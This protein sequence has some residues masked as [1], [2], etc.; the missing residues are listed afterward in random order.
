ML[1]IKELRKQLEMTQVDLAIEMGVSQNT[2]SNW[3]SELILPRTR[4][5]PRLAEVLHCTISDLFKTEAI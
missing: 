4:E 2:I 3:E 5:L 1:R